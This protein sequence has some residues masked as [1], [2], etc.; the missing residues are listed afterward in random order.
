MI[1]K[2]MP[3]VLRLRL[4]LRRAPLCA[5]LAFTACATSPRVPAP[6][7]AA[8]TPAPAT[9]TPADD[10][11]GDPAEA[12][13]YF[14]ARAGSAPNDLV[15]WQRLASA[16]RKVNRLQEAARAG[17]H[18][19]EL[20]P[21]WE[22]WTTLGNVLMQGQGRTAAWAAFEMAARERKDADGVAQTFLNIGYQDWGLGRET[23]AAQA[24]D[25]AEKASPDYTGV[26]Y[27][28]AGLMAFLGRADEARRSA[29]R[30]LELLRRGPDKLPRQQSEIMQEVLRRFLAGDKPPRP[31]LVDSSQVLPDRFRDEHQLGRALAL[32]IDPES[33]RIYPAGSG[34]LFRV[35]VPSRWN[36]AAVI[37]LEGTKVT[38]TADASP[39]PTVVML[40]ILPTPKTVDLR[41]ATEKGAGVVRQ[42]GGQ[43]DPIQTLPGSKG[44]WFWSTDPTSKP[45]DP[46]DFP[47]LAQAFAQAGGVLVSATLLTRANSPA[48]H[49]QL[50]DLMNTAGT[51]S[52]EKP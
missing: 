4:C 26:H 43:V 11:P 33:Y 25:R 9:P 38:L 42:N 24:I 23:A 15:A 52:I 6:G 13:R 50:V 48:D 28:R 36:E 32:T 17:W 22:S 8:A 19:V 5:A 21:T 29:E 10:G 35:K 20:A 2:H 27:D 16:L 45:G 30:A 46:A 12:V 49:A 41:E 7:T 37:Q 14:A 1:P 31:L 18:A 44:F 47:Y 40:T 39:A 51:V 34:H 3:A